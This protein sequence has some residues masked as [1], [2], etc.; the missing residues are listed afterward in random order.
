MSRVL[1][2]T[3]VLIDHLRGARR[4]TVDESIEGC[5]SVMTRLELFVGRVADEP[6]VETLL[7]GFVHVDV[8]SGIA[9]EAG[10]LRRDTRLDVPDAVIAAT[11]LIHKLPLLT[12]NWRHFSRVKGLSRY[13]A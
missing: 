12:R 3:D 5:C 11:A 1:V 2:D 13:Q 10:R 6:R 4:L 8:D 9:A 7:R